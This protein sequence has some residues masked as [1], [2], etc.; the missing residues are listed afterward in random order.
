[1]VTGAGWQQ[2][3]TLQINR[4]IANYQPSDPRSTDRIPTS[5][6]NLVSESGFPGNLKRHGLRLDE[7]HRSYV[8]SILQR[9]VRELAHIDRL[10]AL[11]NLLKLLAARGSGLLNT[12]NLTRDARIPNST[13]ERYLALFD[14]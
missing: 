4:R 9:D 11:P 13:L 3:F 2:N 5:L 7:W 1:M 6:P 10:T 8:T 14:L 12:S